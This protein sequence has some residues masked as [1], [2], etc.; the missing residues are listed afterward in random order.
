MLIDIDTRK[1]LKFSRKVEY[2]GDEV[3]IEIKYTLLFKHCTTCGM[4][5]HEKNYCPTNDVQS[6]IQVPDRTDVFT[7]MQLPDDRHPSY[8]TGRD[9]SAGNQRNYQS[10]LQLREDPPPRS[11]IR[12]RY[13]DGSSHREHMKEALMQRQEA[14][15]SYSNTWE[16]NRW[17]GNSRQ[18][19]HSDQ[20]IRR[21]DDHLRNHMSSGA[22]A[23]SGPYDRSKT[24]TWKEKS[25]L[26]DRSS[27]H[28]YPTNRGA[29]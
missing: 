28:V 17:N 12:A 6:R 20:I 9:V 13:N 8:R 4:L 16:A 24:Q 15:G 3:T 7:R 14:R 2:K 18:S 29:R 1:P 19:S 26:S 22:R 23:R 5:T 25:K 11:N 21:R 10:S 27:E